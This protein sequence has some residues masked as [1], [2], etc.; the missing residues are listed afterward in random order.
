VRG[1]S[2]RRPRRTHLPSPPDNRFRPEGP[3]VRPAHGQRPGETEHHNYYLW[4]GVQ[5]AQQANYSPRRARLTSR[6]AA[7]Y[8][9]LKG[10]ESFSAALH[11]EECALDRGVL[12]RLPG[13]PSGRTPTRE[14][15]SPERSKYAIVSKILRPLKAYDI[16]VV[17]FPNAL[18]SPA[19]CR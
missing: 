15:Q 4:C 11:C 12:P 3:T 19:T 2:T 17:L 13:R 7:S 5:S 8:F 10:F 14:F 1:S 18:P 16:E 9:H 6:D